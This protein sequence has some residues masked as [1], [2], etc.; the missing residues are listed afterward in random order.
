MLLSIVAPSL[1]KHTAEEL[2]DALLGIEHEFILDNWSDGVPRARGALVA[3]LEH[4]THIEPIALRRNVNRMSGE[5]YNRLAVL[6]CPIADLPNKGQ[7]VRYDVDCGFVPIQTVDSKAVYPIRVGHMAGSITRTQR[8]LDSGVDLDQDVMDLSRE[9]CLWAWSNKLRVYI[10]PS[11]RYYANEQ[12]SL[13]PRNLET[14]DLS[15]DV[16][17]LWRREMV[18]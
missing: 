11:F 1:T 5:S 6:I 3:L 9:F 4:D 10:D 8:L 2:S 16:S 14:P 18:L 7:I 12:P 13:T 15:Q 17:L